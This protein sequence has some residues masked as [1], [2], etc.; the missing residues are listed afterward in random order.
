MVPRERITFGRFSAEGPKT[1]RMITVGGS[2]LLAIGFFTG[3]W[4]A[5]LNSCFGTKF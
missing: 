3:Q 1:T 5:L 2:I 4:A